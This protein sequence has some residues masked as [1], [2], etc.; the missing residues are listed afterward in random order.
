MERLNK[1]GSAGHGGGVRHVL[2]YFTFV[3]LFFFMA[4]A[5]AADAPKTRLLLNLTS[6]DVWTNQMALGY[7][8][9]AMDMGYELVVF[10]NVRAVTLAHR[11]VPQPVEP[12]RQ[13]TARDELTALMARGARVF[14]CP[15]CTRRAGMSQEDWIDGVEP[16]GPELIALQMDPQSKVMSY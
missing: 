8:N 15:S 16:G 10:L 12:Q 7:A 14:V 6:D 11:S 2:K 13:M 5:A 1:A 9:K 4:Q 3:A